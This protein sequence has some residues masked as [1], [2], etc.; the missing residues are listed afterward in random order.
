[1]PLRLYLKRQHLPMLPF[2]LGK[3]PC[4][5][6]AGPFPAYGTKKPGNKFAGHLSGRSQ[7]QPDKDWDKRNYCLLTLRV[8]VRLASVYLSRY[9]PLATV[10]ISILAS[11]AVILIRRTTLP[12]RSVIRIFASLAL[13]P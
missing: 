10:L 6:N 3:D 13:S 2:F 8:C 7:H 12:L 1:M 11:L 4:N 9:M 5:R